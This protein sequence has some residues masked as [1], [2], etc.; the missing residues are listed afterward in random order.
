[1]QGTKEKRAPDR[2]A[3][4]AVVLSYPDNQLK[5]Q[6]RSIDE[7]LSAFTVLRDTI[8]TKK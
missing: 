7:T 2:K 1:M 5:R 4:E 8:F 3:D 6:V